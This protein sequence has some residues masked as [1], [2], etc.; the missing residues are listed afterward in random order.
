MRGNLLSALFYDFEHSM[1][2]MGVGLRYKTTMQNAEA[3]RVGA[4]GPM[5]RIMGVLGSAGSLIVLNGR[6]ETANTIALHPMTW[7]RS[8]G[9]R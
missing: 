3:V 7:M 4:R 8:A 6:I 2:D 9:D 1:T 5:D